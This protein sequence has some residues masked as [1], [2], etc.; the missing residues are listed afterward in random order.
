MAA[1]QEVSEQENKEDSAMTDEDTAEL[2]RQFD[3]EYMKRYKKFN[4]EQDEG[5]VSLRFERWRE[6]MA[7]FD[8]REAKAWD[9]W[10]EKVEPEWL[11]REEKAWQA[12]LAEHERQVTDD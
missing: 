5:F 12:R 4:D 7:E 1:Q 11:D 2:L 6:F 9:E 10:L 8:A 3:A